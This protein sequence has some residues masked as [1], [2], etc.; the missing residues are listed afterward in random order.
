MSK[1]GSNTRGGRVYLSNVRA[2]RDLNVRATT[3]VTVDNIS[4][5]GDIRVEVTNEVLHSRVEE[6]T[7]T[8]EQ[9]FMMKQLV[10]QVKTTPRPADAPGFFQ[11]SFH[12]DS[13]NGKI[14]GVCEG[15]ADD[16]DINPIWLRAGFV[17]LACFGIGT[18]IGLYLLARIL[19]PDHPRKTAA[20]LP[21]ASDDVPPELREAWRE[22]QELTK[23]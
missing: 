2:G 12:R 21:E 22:V 7:S 18:G 9:D 16:L 13:E 3:S 8:V 1:Q 17:A 4:A 14:C 23:N 10:E 11:R 6:T 19:L 15:L 20:A 5:G